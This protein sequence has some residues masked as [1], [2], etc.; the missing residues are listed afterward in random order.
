MQPLVSIIMPVFNREEFLENTVTSVIEQSYE[1]WELIIVDDISSDNSLKI[2]RE[3]SKQDSRIKVFSRPEKKKKGANVCRNIGFYISRGDYVNWFDSDDIMS[4]EFIEEKVNAFKDNNL[5]LVLS[6]TILVY[7]DGKKIYEKR[8]NLT[9]NLLED[10]ITT[11]VSWYLPDGMFKRSFL[12]QKKIFEEDL[13]AGQD[14]DFY[15]RII[16]D[17]RVKVINL[18][19]TEYIFHEKSISQSMYRS[20]NYVTQ[21]SVC[22]NL[23]DQVLFLKQQAKLS[24]KLRK[25]YFEEIKNKLPAVMKCNSLKKEYFEILYVLS[26]GTSGIFLQWIYI[27]LSFISFLIFGKGER[28]LKMRIF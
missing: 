8:T 4:R 3:L 15:I 21:L 16:S 5:D 22:K 23:I 27:L 25:H 24:P 6:K 14:R 11:K 18:Y 17:C 12:N 7:P 13:L 1:N 28:V 26:K 19:L 2:A 10:Y 20:D 9:E